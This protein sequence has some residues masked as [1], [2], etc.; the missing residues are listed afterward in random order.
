MKH[1]A[2]LTLT[3]STLTLA[4]LAL[5]TWT[6]TPPAHGQA[7]E[8][9]ADTTVDAAATEDAVDPSGPSDEERQA[10]GRA[11]IQQVV[12]AHGGDAFREQTSQTSR[13]TGRLRPF[14]QA[15]STDVERLAVYKDFPDRDRI[16]MT[17]PQGDV[18]Q[19]FDGIEGWIIN[20]G[21]MIDQTERLQNRRYFGY[22]VLRRF[23]DTFFAKQ[24]DDETVEDVD[25][26]VVRI[27]DKEG[28]ATKVMIRKGD[29]QVFQVVYNLDGQEITERYTEYEAHGGVQVPTRIELYQANAK[30]LEF[31]VDSV[32]VGGDI[33]ASLFEKPQS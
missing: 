25:Y 14:G 33:D 8:K 10:N 4:L 2:Q 1:L 29:H 11:L 16:E 15:M 6:L 27:R 28:H 30:V 5:V 23:D 18:I 32:E 19:V 13:G 24:L 21:Q 31:N 22:D 9:A 20:V 7:A 26:S 3:F 17:L 12:A